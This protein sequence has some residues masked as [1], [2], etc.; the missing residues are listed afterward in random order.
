MHKKCVQF[1]RTIRRKQYCYGSGIRSLFLR[2]Q[3]N[4]PTGKIPS[5]HCMK[6]HIFKLFFI[7]QRRK[8]YVSNYNFFFVVSPNFYK[9]LIQKNSVKKSIFALHCALLN[10]SKY[11]IQI[12]FRRMK[13]RK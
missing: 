13:S 2:I 6:L 12:R 7:H 11:T 3:N 1:L 5:L 10:I 4:F 9:Y 8:I